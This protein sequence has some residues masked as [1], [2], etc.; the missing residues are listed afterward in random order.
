MSGVRNALAAAILLGAIN[1]AD[2]AENATCSQAIAKSF[3]DAL[4]KQ[5]KQALTRIANHP[6]LL[7]EEAMQYLAGDAGYR[8][9]AKRDRRS[10]FVLL[11]NHQVLTKTISTQQS[12]GT[13]VVEVVYLPT[14][15]AVSFVEL[16]QRVRSN[17]ATPFVDYVA[18]RFEVRGT[19]VR[20]PNACY[21]ESDA[22]E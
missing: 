6:G 13:T 14:S 18:C 20:M 15:T 19:S 10:A 8:F 9:G 4:L 7:D 5:D 21:A 2:A 3:L 17:R 12:D 16:D 1:V 11:R 22:L